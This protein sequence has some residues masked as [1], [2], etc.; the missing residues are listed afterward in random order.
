M[1][2]ISP[3]SCRRSTDN[4]FLPVYNQSV[5]KWILKVFIQDVWVISL[6]PR[7]ACVGKYSK[8]YQCAFPRLI[9]HLNRTDHMAD[10]TLEMWLRHAESQVAEIRSDHGRLPFCLL[11][12]ALTEYLPLI[13][14]AI[15]LFTLSPL[16]HLFFFFSLSREKKSNS[17]VQSTERR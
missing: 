14:H 8:I 6:T 7:F 10:K 11:S 13:L 5:S 17:S 3:S 16:C 4:L 12:S 9:N 2:L 15:F 1:D